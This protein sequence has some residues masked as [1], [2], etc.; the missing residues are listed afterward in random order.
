MT[1]PISPAIPEHD[2]SD[3]P[4]LEWPLSRPRELAPEERADVRRRLAERLA[5]HPE[6]LFAYLHGS[7]AEE[8][9]FRDI[10]IGIFLTPEAVGTLDVFDYETALYSELTHMVRY[11]WDVDQQRV[12]GYARHDL[13]DFES[14]LIAIEQWLESERQ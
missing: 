6:I 8:L 2:P 1:E 4:A 13:A 14:Y 11:E 7:F 5:G 10:D 3:A 9:P 12:L